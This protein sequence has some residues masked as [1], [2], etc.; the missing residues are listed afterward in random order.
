MTMKKSAILFAA[1]MLAAATAYGQQTVFTESQIIRDP[2]AAAMSGAGMADCSSMAYSSMYNMA[3]LPFCSPKGEVAASYSMIPE[4]VGLYNGGV[5][6]G[7]GFKA[8]NKLGFSLGGSFWNAA[9]Y[10]LIDET[11]LADGTF[12]PSDIMI[13]GGL[14]IK[15][16][17]FLGLGA[18]A[19]YM[20]RKVAPDYSISAVSINAAAYARFGGF[21]ASLGICSLGN[22]KDPDGNT[23]GLPAHA[24]AGACYRT[25]LGE[26]SEIKACA[27][28]RIY[29]GGGMGI[30]AG[31]EYNWTGMVFVRGGY[32]YCAEEAPLPS[33]WSAGAGLKLSGVRIDFA[34]TALGLIFGLGYSF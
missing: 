9:E 6:F 5:N 29:L 22:V 27:D 30:A 18:A 19:G 13:S 26:S 11:G 8:G 14:G 7:A 10:E 3:T 34:Y 21:G 20:S 16:T 4:S 24:F 32:S 23:F 25:N 2:K 15:L 31:L 1:C 33:S 12:K 28:A 17:E